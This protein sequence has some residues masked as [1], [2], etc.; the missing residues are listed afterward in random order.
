MDPARKV[1][2]LAFSPDG[3]ILISGAKQCSLRV[4]NVK[5]GDC[6]LMLEQEDGARDRWNSN[7]YKHGP[8]A[9]E[10]LFGDGEA[11]VAIAFPDGSVR[12]W[13]VKWESA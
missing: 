3:R 4:W 7:G 1:A 8:P 12:V 13:D 11:K 9:F 10:V 6:L 2:A 5:G